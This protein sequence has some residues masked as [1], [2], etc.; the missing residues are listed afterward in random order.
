MYDDFKPVLD[1]AYKGSTVIIDMTRFTSGQELKNKVIVAMTDAAR[2]V[3]GRV[4]T[5]SDRTV[6]FTPN[7]VRMDMYRNKK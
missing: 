6:I 4:M 2:D 1:M 3:G 7:G 5:L